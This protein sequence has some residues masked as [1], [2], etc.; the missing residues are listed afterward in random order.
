M[1]M[2]F[3]E[4]SSQPLLVRLSNRWRQRNNT[5]RE[6]PHPSNVSG[7]R[8]DSPSLPHE[9]E[10][11]PTTPR[12]DMNLSRHSNDSP[13]IPRY[14]TESPLTPQ[15]DTESPLTPRL[16]TSIPAYESNNL[17][18]PGSKGDPPISNG[19]YQYATS[20]TEQSNMERT[21]KI[22]KKKVILEPTVSIN[23]K[24]T[25]EMLQEWSKE[26][27]DTNICI[28]RADCVHK[29]LPR[30]MHVQIVLYQELVF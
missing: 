5:S 29:V 17:K 25:E 26:V 14:N 2:Y 23:D 12:Y 3:I 16:D 1:C 11:S 19:H 30:I 10:D 7:Y 28:L 6:E 21:R 22:S 27:R 15:Y 18:S 13:L 8:T 20:T 24:L 4:S 9:D